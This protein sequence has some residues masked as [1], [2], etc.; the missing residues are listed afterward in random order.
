MAHREASPATPP[1][2]RGESEAQSEDDMPELLHDSS[3]SESDLDARTSSSLPPTADYTAHRPRTPDGSVAPHGTMT[4]GTPH[5]N[6][7]QRSRA[8]LLTMSPIALLCCALRSRSRSP[9]AGRSHT[10]RPTGPRG[11]E[12]TEVER[13][14]ETYSPDRNRRL[15]EERRKR[16]ADPRTRGTWLRDM[17]LRGGTPRGSG[18]GKEELCGEERKSA[19]PL[20]TARRNSGHTSLRT[21]EERGFT[22]LGGMMAATDVGLTTLPWTTSALAARAA[23][24]GAGRGSALG[25]SSAHHEPWPTPGRPLASPHSV[26]PSAVATAVATPPAVAT[27]VATLSSCLYTALPPD[28]AVTPTVVP[29]DDVSPPGPGAALLTA[30]PPSPPPS[31]PSSSSDGDEGAEPHP[32]DAA[33]DG[34]AAAGADSMDAGA[35]TTANVSYDEWLASLFLTAENRAAAAHLPAAPSSPAAPGSPV[36]RPQW[37]EQETVSPTQPAQWPE[38][39][40]VTPTQPAARQDGADTELWPTA[41]E[42]LPTQPAQRAEHEE[43]LST[44]PA[45]RLEETPDPSHPEHPE[46]PDHPDDPAAHT[47]WSNTARTTYAT[48][49]VDG[50]QPK[51]SPDAVRAAR[52]L[53]KEQG[54]PARKGLPRNYSWGDGYDGLTEAST[55][56]HVINS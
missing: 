55:R 52:A 25:N 3:D 31:P 7:M 45:E 38:Q 47:A 56:M 36:Q 21:R 50:L 1:R 15:E 53:D 32:L 29:S 18:G 37:P 20:C 42:V 2:A 9:P 5:Q 44:Q 24:R 26:S 33:A 4:S 23:A 12:E 8:E 49:N 28:D 46:H 17:P 11:G 27:S 43:E 14:P 51:P 22:H 6:P 30:P 35:H 54:L 16:V 39:E 41:E 10:A 48:C 40:A 13:Y 19:R 34:P